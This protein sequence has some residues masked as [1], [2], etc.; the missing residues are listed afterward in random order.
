MAEKLSSL[1]QPQQAYQAYQSLL[2]EFPD[3]PDKPTIY[4]ALLPLAQKLDKK[5]EVATYEAALG[6]SAAAKH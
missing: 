4:K 6:M 1:D 5:A 2:R 3:F